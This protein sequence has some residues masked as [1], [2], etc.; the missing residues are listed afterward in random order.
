MAFDRARV[1][2]VC[3]AGLML[4]WLF[5]GY[6]WN[7]WERWAL[8]LFNSL[9]LPPPA[10]PMEF[11]PGEGPH[12]IRSSQVVLVDVSSGDRDPYAIIDR[13]RL[14]QLVRKLGSLKPRVLGIDVMFGDV[15]RSA[16]DVHLAQA[17]REASPVVLIAY[18]DLAGTTEHY[19]CCGLEQAAAA[20]G[21]ANLPVD[22]T[23][24]R[25]RRVQHYF[26][27]PG[28]KTRY[29]FSLVLASYLISA[30]AG[31][32]GAITASDRG[33]RIQDGPG[34]GAQAA[35]DVPI[36]ANGNTL[37]Q[38]QGPAHTVP[39]YDWQEVLAGTVPE[40]AIRH[41]V[42][43]LGNV[44]L[45]QR[46]AF[47][48]P[49]HQDRV[50]RLSGVEIH[51]QNVLALI[52]AYPPFGG[53][54]LRRVV[55]P[56]WQALLS[57][58]GCAVAAFLAWTLSPQRVVVLAPL[59][60]LAAAGGAYLVFDGWCVYVN[61]LGP[62]LGG[63]V[64][65]LVASG[66]RSAE[67][68][69]QKRR[70]ETLMETYFGADVSSASGASAL[71]K[72]ESLMAH[73]LHAREVLAPPGLRID[74]PLGVGGMSVVLAATETATLREIALKFLS[75]SLFRDF[76]SRARFEREARVASI[77]FHPNV[78]GVVTSGHRW[79]IPYIGYERVRGVSLRALLEREKKIAPG[80]AVAIVRQVLSGL[81]AAHAQGIVHRDVKPENAILTDDGVVRVLD[82]G[83]ARQQKSEESFHTRANII[84]GTPA[85]MAPEVVKGQSVAASADVYACGVLLY[86]LISG[87]VAFDEEGATA[88]LLAHLQRTPLSLKDRG[89][90]LPR[91]LDTVIMCFLE[92]DA[93]ARPLSATAASEMP[94]TFDTGIGRVDTAAVGP[95]EEKVERTEAIRPSLQAEGTVRIDSTKPDLNRPLSADRSTKRETPEGAPAGS[96]TRRDL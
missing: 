31:Q 90:D 49:F 89:V 92:K 66:Y 82:F 2:L 74:G 84:L 33:L 52:A 13:Q 47:Y 37:C 60:I 20:L 6:L 34:D 11:N 3:L 69:R 10:G 14:A 36:D 39:R 77:V 87:R 83:I 59:F 8:D 71:P 17:I 61:P 58:A 21:H 65:A 91:A 72:E 63:L 40:T 30:R 32:P 51:G 56:L 70:I 81:A 5:H 4:A 78:V 73:L 45:D 57:L 23:D 53:Q 54:P 26:P 24:G 38:Y 62:I 15:D 80:R 96:S 94:A 86:E 67:I 75:P 85:Y 50:N 1:G 12:T 28:F 48:V 79:G 46:D 41:N 19:P 29:S 43:I 68:E 93:T 22:L 18:H 27:R 76:E 25:V 44:R 9:R 35:I 55:A 95:G 64:A 42:V 7:P 16:H 88:M